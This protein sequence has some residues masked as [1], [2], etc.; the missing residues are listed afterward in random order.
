[1]SPDTVTLMS[2][3]IYKKKYIYLHYNSRHE[4]FFT[5]RFFFSV[6]FFF[7]FAFVSPFHTCVE[8]D[9]PGTKQTDKPPPFLLLVRLASLLFLRSVAVMPWASVLAAPPPHALQIDGEA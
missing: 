1:M 6:S 2:L 4:F 5:Y 8:I 7:P 3:Y 9:T